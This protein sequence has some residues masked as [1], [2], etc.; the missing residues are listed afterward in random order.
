MAG[1]IRLSSIYNRKRMHAG[2]I[3]SDRVTLAAYHPI[4]IRRKPG[5]IHNSALHPPG[6]NMFFPRS[7]ASLT[8]HTRLNIL[9]PGDKIPRSMASETTLPCIQ[10]FPFEPNFVMRGK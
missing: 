6:V 7:M 10:L 8:R 3:L 1:S 4:A 5:W 2:W 9:F